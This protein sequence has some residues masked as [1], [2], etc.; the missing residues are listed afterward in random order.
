M[1]VPD[2]RLTKAFRGGLPGGGRATRDILNHI[3]EETFS[4]D[5]HSLRDRYGRRVH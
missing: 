1:F 2:L 4:S 5:C 3:H